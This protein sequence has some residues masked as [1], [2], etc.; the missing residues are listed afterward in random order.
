M[1]LCR[2]VFPPKV[3]DLQVSSDPCCLIKQRFEVCFCLLH[4]LTNGSQ[5]PTLCKAV[6]VGIYWKGWF[7]VRGV[8]MWTCCVCVGTCM[9]E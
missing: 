4:R 8:Q 1:L 9:V 2:T 6:Y 3:D 7:T 5:A